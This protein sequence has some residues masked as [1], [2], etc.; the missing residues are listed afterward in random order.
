MNCAPLPIS[1]NFWVG[2]VRARG[3]EFDFW[4][5][6]LNKIIVTR[7]Y[8]T[9]T[10]DTRGSAYREQRRLADLGRT[11]CSMP[12]LAASSI[13]LCSGSI[14]RMNNIGDNGSPWRN[15]RACLN[16]L[17]GTPISKILEVE[18]ANKTQSS[19]AIASQSQEPATSLKG[20][21]N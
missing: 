6:Q 4:L 16:F 19:H 15:P 9:S 8:S 13:N 3:L 20:K 14:A 10:S 18:V 7:S 11:W 12:L 1:L 2:L 5:A 21:P 17:P